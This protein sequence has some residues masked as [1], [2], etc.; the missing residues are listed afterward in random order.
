[1]TCPVDN[2]PMGAMLHGAGDLR[3]E[4]VSVEPLGPRDLRI[5]LGAAGICGSDQH[6]FREGRMGPFTLKTPFALGHEMSG[7]VI[8]AGADVLDF[9]TGDRVVVDPALTC[10]GCPECRAG[11]S[12]LCQRVRFMGSASHD[13]HLNGGYRETFVVEAARCVKVPA[14]TPHRVIAV[15]EPLSVAVHAVERAGGL[16]GRDVLIAGAGTIGCL[17]AATA[18]AAG[19]ARICVSDPSEFRRSIALKMGATDVVDPTDRAAIEQIVASGGAFDVGF[20]G[21]GSTAAFHDVV[22][23]VRRGGK[24][25][26]VG[27]IP[28]TECRVPFDHMTTREIDLL[29]TF[30][31]NNV[32][33]RAARMLVDGTIDP[34]PI[35]TGAFD[36]ADV[37]D[38]FQASFDTEH[39]LKV[40]L[41]GQPHAA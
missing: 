35:L 21:S 30:R 22:R 39:H 1:M 24:A 28:T 13:P 15:A 37:H 27:M 20:E 25:V 12:N 17:I 41:L 8:E 31:Q 36:L 6:Y 29:S 3:F 19:A 11:R 2:A 9:A 10:G 14:N 40:M 5:R 16:M 26:L 33:A 4:P 34:E 38:A 32:F 7:D 18:R 23:M